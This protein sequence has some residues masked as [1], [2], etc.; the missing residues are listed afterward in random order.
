[1]NSFANG[2]L[3]IVYDVNFMTCIS[4][5]NDMKFDLEE[6]NSYIDIYGLAN[7]E[8]YS[9]LV[10]E[11]TFDAFNGEYLNILI[12]RDIISIEMI[13]EYLQMIS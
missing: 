10:D 12:G 2:A 6:L 3:N 11:Y 4:S 8:D 7:Y 9:F 13:A 5:I 1:M